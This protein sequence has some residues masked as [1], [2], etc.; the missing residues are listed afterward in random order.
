MIAPAILA[1]V[2]ALGASDVTLLQ[3]QLPLLYPAPVPRAFVDAAD[4]LRGKLPELDANETVVGFMRV[5]ASLGERNGHTGI[6]PLDPGNRRAFHEYP[7]LP[8]EFP[9]GPVVV[10]QLG[11]RDLLGAR[12]E[13]VGGITGI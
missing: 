5:A 3:Q 1:A 2:L 12:I 10:G 6:F 13:S 7:V 9:E 8:Y 11:G 4:E